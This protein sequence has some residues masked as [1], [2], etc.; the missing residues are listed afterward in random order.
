MLLWPLN[1]IFP[2]QKSQLKV[3]ITSLEFLQ[4]RSFNCRITFGQKKKVKDI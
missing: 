4:K 2:E 3:W 1:D